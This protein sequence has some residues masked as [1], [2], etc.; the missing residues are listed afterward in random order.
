MLCVNLKYFQK[1]EL[2]GHNRYS[3]IHHLFYYKSSKSSYVSFSGIIFLTNNQKVV[4]LIE[5]EMFNHYQL[6]HHCISVFVGYSPVDFDHQ[7]CFVIVSEYFP[8]S[9]IFAN[10]CKYFKRKMFY[11]IKY[12]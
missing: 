8:N 2:I 12:Q 1:S 4:E 6:Y 11:K 3:N 7:R 10:I 9:I 5:Q